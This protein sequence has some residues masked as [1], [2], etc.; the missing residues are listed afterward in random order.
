MATRRGVPG[1]R[2]VERTFSEYLAMMTQRKPTPTRAPSLGYKGKHDWLD[3]SDFL[4]HLIRKGDGAY[5]S[6][7]SILGGGALKPGPKAFGAA[8]EMGES[9]RSVCFS[10]VPLGYLTRFMASRSTMGIAFHKSVAVARGCAPVWYVR[11]K[12]KP[13]RAIKKLIAEAKASGN[14]DAPVWSLTPFIDH[15]AAAYK[16]EFEWER[17]W[18]HVGHFAF[19][20]SDVAFLLLEE[21]NHG[22]A[23]SFFANAEA[24]D[25]GP[26]YPCPYIDPRWSPTR[27]AAV[28]GT[29]NETPYT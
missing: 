6:F 3:M 16:Y 8:R 26:N 10:E 20:P 25:S 17:E 1:P 13:Y 9:Q 19:A 28:L 18:R 15:P 27:V 11:P 23:R 24:E 21:E 14:V 12:G 7:M 29:M 2:E 5:R 22:P 4:V